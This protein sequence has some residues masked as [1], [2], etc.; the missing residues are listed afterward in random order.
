MKILPGIYR[1]KYW[2]SSVMIEY[3]SLIRGEEIKV[4]GSGRFS[5]VCPCGEDSI[6]EF[7]E[8]YELNK[9]FDIDKKR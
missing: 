8:Y 9:K 2:C 4:L 3:I 6:L 1:V 5:T 7:I